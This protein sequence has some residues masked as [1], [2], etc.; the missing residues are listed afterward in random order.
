MEIKI[1]S[2]YT[3]KEQ[4][5]GKYKDI[6][7]AVEKNKMNLTWAN[8]TGADLKNIQNYSQNHQIAFEIIKR[9]KRDYFTQK[10]WSVIGEISI[11]LPC[12]NT[13]IKKYGKTAI[14][15]CK[16]LAKLGFNE[17]YDTIKKERIK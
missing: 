13:I 11:H 12:W 17:Y 2:S 1:K 14:S 8:L 10:E 9:Q 6:R 16:K 4:R 15:I 7:E 5:S 3:G